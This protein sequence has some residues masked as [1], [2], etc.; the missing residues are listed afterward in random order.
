MYITMGSLVVIEKQLLGEQ[1]PGLN[2]EDQYTM[3]VKK[4]SC[5]TV[6]CLPQKIVVATQQGSEIASSHR[7]GLPTILFWPSQTGR[8]GAQL[9]VLA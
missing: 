5:I 8:I 4:D 2:V 3:A 6:G 1:K 7:Y 9:T